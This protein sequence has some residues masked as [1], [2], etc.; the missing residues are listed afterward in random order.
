VA[1]CEQQS[2]VFESSLPGYGVQVLCGKDGVDHWRDQITWDAVFDNIRIVVST[3]QVLLD[4]LSHGFVKMRKLALIIF[5]EAHHCTGKHP[6]HTILA[7]FYTPYLQMGDESQLPKIL[8][9]SASPVQKAK[10]S[11]SDL[12]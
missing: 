7:N 4:A 2:K 10:A 8:G 12:Q 11:G 1:L 9:L 5:D 3:P 6:T